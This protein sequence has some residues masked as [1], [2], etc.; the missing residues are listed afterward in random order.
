[1]DGADVVDA[2]MARLQAI[3][4]HLLEPGLTHAVAAVETLELAHVGVLHRLAVDRPGGAM[5]VRRAL[6]RLGI[7]E[8]QHDEAEIPVLVEL[9]RADRGGGAG[10]PPDARV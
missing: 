2:G 8:R 5:V 1:M 7:A 10:R 6:A 3:A 4:L 9:A